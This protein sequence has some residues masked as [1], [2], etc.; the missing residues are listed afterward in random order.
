MVNKP[1]ILILSGDGINCE[2]E[3]A[4]AF[5]MAGGNPIIVH[6]ND[7][8][9]NPK[10]LDFFQGLALPGGF[11]F[12][13]DLGSGQI[14][15][16]KIKFGLGEVLDRFVE[17]K[18]PIIGI[19][20]GFQVLIKLGF[21]GNH[22]SL[23]ANKN[24]K[25]INRWVNLTFPKNESCVWTKGLTSFR[26]PI[27]HGEGRFMVK[28]VEGGGQSFYQKLK[29]RGQVAVQYAEDVNGSFYNIA[30][31]CDPRGFI[32]GLMPHPEAAISS[33]TNCQR[34]GGSPGKGIFS[35]IIQFINQS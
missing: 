2:R 20:N 30:G 24:R 15:A 35:N 34:D 27:R 12:G 23:V 1:N 13:D 21:F 18:R 14:L 8:L 16:L 4:H 31:L 32:L 3:T 17:E 22:I 5:L 25:F 6:I 33:L 10:K 29:G 28:T 11:S 19:C 9:K 26:L 7:L